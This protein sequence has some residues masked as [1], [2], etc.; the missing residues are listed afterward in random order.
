MIEALIIPALIALLVGAGL[1][2]WQALRGPARRRSALFR[3]GALL[4][5]TFA[6]SVLWAAWTIGKSRTFQ[7]FGQMVRHVNTSEKVVA[8]T[9]DD[10]PTSYATEKILAVL[11]EKEVK[12]TFFLIGAELAQYPE[13]GRLIYSAGHEIGNHSYSHDRMFFKSPSFISTE[14]ERT[15][16]LIRQTGWQGTIHFRS[17]FGKRLLLLPWYLYRHNRLNIFW[18]LEPDSAPELAG[19]AERMARHVTDKVQPGSIILLHVMYPNRVESFKAVPLIID[20]LKAKGYR[21][22]RLSELLALAQ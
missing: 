3:R 13:G 14:I 11:R 10:G 20:G 12:A 15:D 18:D 1:L 6:V 16:E 7:F 8:L 21:F 5:I 4:F 19:S 22:A 9:F 17:P 2:C